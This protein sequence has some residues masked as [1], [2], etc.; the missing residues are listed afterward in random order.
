MQILQRSNRMIAIA[1]ETGT[2]GLRQ[3]HWRIISENFRCAGMLQIELPQSK[4]GAVPKLRPKRADGTCQDQPGSFGHDLRAFG[5]VNQP[6]AAQD[7][8]SDEV[9]DF[10]LKNHIIYHLKVVWRSSVLE[11]FPR[12]WFFV[13]SCYICSNMSAPTPEFLHTPFLAWQTCTST[14]HG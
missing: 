3:C 14:S 10:K 1:R 2:W 13:T 9:G 11:D 6:R 4:Y 8:R 5:G 7:I 12:K